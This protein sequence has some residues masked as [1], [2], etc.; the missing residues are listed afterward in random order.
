MVHHKDTCLAHKLFPRFDFFKHVTP[1]A[2][3]EPIENHNWELDAFWE[4]G[5]GYLAPK[6]LCSREGED[7]STKG[8]FYLCSR[9]GKI[10]T[11]LLQS[12]LENAQVPSSPLLLCNNWGDTRKENNQIYLLCGEVHV[13]AQMCLES[14][15][16][17]SS[18]PFCLLLQRR[19]TAVLLMGWSCQNN[20]I[21]WYYSF[22]AG[23]VKETSCLNMLNYW[24][25]QGRWF[26]NFF[27]IDI[28]IN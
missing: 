11:E 27:L 12:Q 25:L 17:Q 3:G 18:L 15:H 21:T 7:L 23:E 16:F 22:S 19:H 14:S 8:Y 28:F 10:S 6:M 5:G 24:N 1:V 9:T 13:V 20:Y 26:C 2:A 4:A